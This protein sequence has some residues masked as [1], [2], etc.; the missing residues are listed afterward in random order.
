M[1]SRTDRNRAL[2]ARVAAKAEIADVRILQSTFALEKFPAGAQR[3]GWTLELEPATE[4]DAGDD[5][6]VVSCRYI[7]TIDE[8]AE[9][10][11]SQT[12]DS[13]GAVARIEF[14][15]AALYELGY[16]DSDLAPTAEEVTAFGASTG[17]FALYP[18]AR[19]YAQDVST[20]LG[21]PPL[22]LSIYRVPISSPEGATVEAPA[23]TT[24]FPARF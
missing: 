5:H 7:V 18:Y 11:S 8:V 15:M 21:L 1:S 20:R 3:L 13:D 16:A 22:T 4:F 12:A 2:A 24:G 10:D 9:E 23:A 14:T 17:A 19:A 6:F